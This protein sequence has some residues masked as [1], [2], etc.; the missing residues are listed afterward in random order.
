LPLASKGK[1]AIASSVRHTDVAYERC[2]KKAI[3]YSD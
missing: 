1:D 3:I 2:V